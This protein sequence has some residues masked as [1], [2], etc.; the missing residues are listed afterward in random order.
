M[1]YSPQGH[2][3]SHTTE[4]ACMLKHVKHTK[5]ARAGLVLKHLRLRSRVALNAAW[6]QRCLCVLP[7]HVRGQPACNSALSPCTLLV[8]RTFSSQQA[9][10]TRGEALTHILAQTSKLLLGQ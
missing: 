4:H 3:E 7:V 8:P 5:L 2:K 10:L 9:F 1:G 6:D